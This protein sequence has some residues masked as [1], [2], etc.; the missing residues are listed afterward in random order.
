MSRT[1]MGWERSDVPGTD[2]EDVL[3]R[4]SLRLIPCCN[5]LRRYC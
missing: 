5:G 3:H 1:E 4:N 2:V